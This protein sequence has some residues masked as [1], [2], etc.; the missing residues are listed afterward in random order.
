MATPGRLND[1]L[2]MGVIGLNNCS[3]LVLDE[4]DRMLDMGFE[5]QIRNIIFSLRRDRQTLMW[6][7]T[8]PSEVRSLAKE[9][10]TDSIQINVGSEELQANQNIKQISKI[11]PHTGK[12]DQ[13]LKD[14][15]D[16]INN[17]GKLLIFTNLKVMADFLTS[18]IRAKRIPAASIHSDKS[19]K[20]RENMLYDFKHGVYNVLIATNVAARG[21][22]IDDIT[23]VINYDCPP[24]AEQYVHRIGRTARAGKSGISITYFSEGSTE[25]M[26]AA[27]AI[28]ALQKHTKDKDE[29]LIEFAQGAERWNRN[30]S[31]RQTLNNRRFG[32]MESYNS[33]RKRGDYLK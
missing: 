18:K 3:F 25:D 11:V 9:F 15:Q 13:C 2:S 23:H 26:Q 31:S 14:V 4:A 17:D 28:I 8:W 30:V 7:A 12:L 33:F 22:D 29:K 5:R 19:Q 21:L 32:N 27:K 20:E 6:S 24:T 10:L 16:I 1:F